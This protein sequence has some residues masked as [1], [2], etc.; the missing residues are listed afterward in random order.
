[1]IILMQYITRC[2]FH[3]QGNSVFLSSTAATQKGV[4]YV[5]AQ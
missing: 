4:V 5:V 3:W 2:I 1:M